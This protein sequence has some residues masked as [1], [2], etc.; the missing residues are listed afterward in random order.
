LQCFAR[1]EVG[2]PQYHCCPAAPADP[3]P[4]ISTTLSLLRI[5]DTPDQPDHLSRRNPVI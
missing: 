5:A 4:D 1:L 3:C 2:A